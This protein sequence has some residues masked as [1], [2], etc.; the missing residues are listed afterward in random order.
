MLTLSIVVIGLACLPI[1]DKPKYW[2][3]LPIL[4]FIA[5]SMVYNVFKKQ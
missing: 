2:L 4:G 5:I 1:E 3:T